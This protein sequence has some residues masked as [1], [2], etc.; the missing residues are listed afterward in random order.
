[1][2]KSHILSNM[3]HPLTLTLYYSITAQFWLTKKLYE[4]KSTK[5]AVIVLYEILLFHEI[6]TLNLENLFFSIC[7]CFL[8]WI[9]I[10]VI[11]NGLPETG[12]NEMPLYVK[13]G[14]KFLYIYMCMWMCMGSCSWVWAP[15]EAKRGCDLTNV[16]PRN[17][18]QIFEK[19]SMC[20]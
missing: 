18:A 11:A 16:S 1:M 9:Q 7:H 14:C 13:Y 19:N 3:C 5:Y 15:M 10:Y 4:F 20:S 2:K 8:G 6:T 12:K 17:W